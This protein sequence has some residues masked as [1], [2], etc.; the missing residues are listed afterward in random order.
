[1]GASAIDRAGSGSD[2]ERVIVKTP[3]E[4]PANP[5]HWSTRSMAQASGLEVH[6]ILVRAD[7]AY[8][9]GCPEELEPLVH[10]AYDLDGWEESWGVPFEE[11]S[12]EAVE[13][14]KEF[15]SKRPAAEAGN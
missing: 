3:E 4:R 13:A 12:R 5:T 11:L 10:C 2:V 1:M 7:I 9:L 14:A 6:L 8:N 15:L